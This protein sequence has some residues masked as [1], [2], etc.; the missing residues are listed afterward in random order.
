MDATGEVERPQKRVKVSYNDTIET[1]SIAQ[2]V[3]DQDNRSSIASSFNLS[4]A[5]LKVVDSQ[6]CTVALTYDG[7][8]ANA[9]YKISMATSPRAEARYSSLFACHF[10]NLQDPPANWTHS[11]KF[12]PRLFLEALNFMH[13]SSKFQNMTMS[14]C[15][16]SVLVAG[17]ALLYPFLS[18]YGLPTSTTKH[19]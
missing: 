5:G 3:S 4:P 10:L 17:M 13:V 16:A 19:I 12:F 7:L 14:F 11:D 18:C 6:A 9:E 1:F 2:H 8:H 15:S